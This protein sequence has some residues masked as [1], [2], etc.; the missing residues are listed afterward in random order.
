LSF[1]QYLITYENLNE[2]Q[3]DNIKLVICVLKFH[4]QL[5]QCWQL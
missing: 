1:S 5:R 4:L 3:Q 2:V